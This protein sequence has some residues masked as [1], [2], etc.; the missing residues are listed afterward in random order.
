M[1]FHDIPANRIQQ[2]FFIHFLLWSI[3]NTPEIFVLLDIPEVSF[4]LD[5]SCLPFQDPFFA[6]YIRIGLLPQ[7]F[8]SFIDLHDL[9]L[10][11]IFFSFVFIETSG[12][13]FTAAAV[14]APVY[15]HC[16]GVAILLFALCPDMPQFPSVMADVIMLIFKDSV[17][18]LKR[19]VSSQTIGRT[20]FWNWFCGKIILTMPISRS[21]ETEAKEES[22]VCRWMNFCPSL[23]KTKKP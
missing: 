20:I 12:F 1:I 22:M 10:V 18:L 17:R 8:P 13:V 16:L 9:I 15:F 21:K 5:R 4:R 7:F 19:A 2:E 23:E 6:L 14:C 3:V 11:R